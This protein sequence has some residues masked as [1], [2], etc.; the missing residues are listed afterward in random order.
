MFFCYFFCFFEIFSSFFLK[1]GK[2]RKDEGVRHLLC[3]LFFKRKGGNV[4]LKEEYK[5]DRCCPR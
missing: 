5:A 4:A 2:K 3:P 1:K